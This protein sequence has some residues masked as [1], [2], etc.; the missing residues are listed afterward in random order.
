MQGTAAF[1][2]LDI[3]DGDREPQQVAAPPVLAASFSDASSVITVDAHALRR[4]DSERLGVPVSLAARIPDQT[5]PQT[6]G[7]CSLGVTD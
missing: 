5:F 2:A 6:A 4:T 1:S 7:D 3:R